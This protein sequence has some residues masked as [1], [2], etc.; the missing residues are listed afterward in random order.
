MAEELSENVAIGH[1]DIYVMAFGYCSAQDASTG[2]GGG[3]VQPRNGETL[4]GCVDRPGLSNCAVRQYIPKGSHEN[5]T[6]LKRVMRASVA[7]GAAGALVFGGLTACSSDDDDSDSASNP[8]GKPPNC[9]AIRPPAIRS[10]SDSSRPRAG[11]YQMPML[12]TSGEAAARYLNEN[13][14]GIGGH[15]DRARRV[16]SSP[17]PA[18]ATK[19]ANEMV[20]EGGRGPHAAELAGR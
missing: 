15:E 14:G 10:R 11:G 5:C 8:A 7:V 19:C 6:L 3:G 20:E 9:R 12:R 17:R 16:Q 13:G 1:S 18:S 4:P 2:H